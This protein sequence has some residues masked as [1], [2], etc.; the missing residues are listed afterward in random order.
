M[1]KSFEINGFKRYNHVKFD[2]LGHINLFLGSNNAGKSTILEAIFSFVA[3]KNITALL[4]NGLLRRSANVNG[5]Y[6]F[7]ERLLGAQHN[8]NIKPFTFSFSATLD[9]GRKHTFEHTLEPYGIFA[10]F[11]PTLMGSFGN[12]QMENNLNAMN[13]PGQPPI[14]ITPVGKWRIKENNKSVLRTEIGFPPVSPD[15]QKGPFQLGRFVDILTHREQQENTKIYS[16]LKRERIM[17][18]FISELQKTFPDIQD[19]DSIPFPDGTPSPVSFKIRDNQL[20]PMYNFGDG[21]QR[22]YNILGGLILYQN[23]IH[24]LEEVDATF[25]PS[26]QTDLSRNLY[27]YAKK[28]NNQLFMTSHSIEF[29]DNLLHAIYENQPE[30][31]QDIVRIITLKSD[32][33][34]NEV[35]SRVLTGREA[36]KTREKYQLELR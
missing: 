33:I 6:D 31:E 28:F 36:Y 17:E 11:K 26:A 27:K 1:L 16:F 13:I 35:H 23:A 32:P 18:E 25:H 9:T 3:G 29:V 21:V 5:T 19:I 15:L 4:A 24:C 22:W 2:D 12:I 30:D 20:L 7:I 14:N 8:Q 10:D 34:T